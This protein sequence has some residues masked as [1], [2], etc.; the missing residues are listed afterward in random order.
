[1]SEPAGLVIEDAYARILIV[2]KSNVVEFQYFSVDGH[3]TELAVDLDTLRKEMHKLLF[4]GPS[5][6]EKA[7]NAAHMEGRCL[8][9]EAAIQVVLDAL[10]PLDALHY[11]REQ[12]ILNTLL[13]E[14]RDII[15]AF[16]SEPQV[17]T[18]VAERD[19]FSL[20][21]AFQDCRGDGHYT[22]ARCARQIRGAQ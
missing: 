7:V 2:R 10:E 14:L 8:G 13:D 4:D 21:Q 1:M 9:I 15:R 12:D 18:T 5:V 20:R 19:C 3:G 17:A 16:E 22:C 11:D 6:G